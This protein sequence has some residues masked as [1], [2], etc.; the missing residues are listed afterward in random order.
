MPLTNFKIPERYAYQTGFLANLEYV[1]FQLG[2]IDPKRL[3]L[4]G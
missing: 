4:L 1:L 3:I 2:I